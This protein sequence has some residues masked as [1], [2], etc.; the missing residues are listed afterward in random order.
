M[1]MTFTLVSHLREQL[2]SLVR[3]RA[4]RL[5]AEEREKE[6]LAIEVTLSLLFRPHGVYIARRRKRGLVELRSQWR[7]SKHG[8]LSLV[9]R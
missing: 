1:A 3:R 2:S 4:D 8:K 9:A 7:H 6:R 5:V